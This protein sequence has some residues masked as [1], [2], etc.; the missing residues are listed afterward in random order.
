MRLNFFGAAQTVTGSQHLLEVNGKTLLLDCGLFQGRRKEAFRRNKEFD[1]DVAKLDAVVLSH[2]H[3]D[4][5]GN[6]PNLVKQGYSGPI[7]AQRAT[8]HLADIMLQDSGHIQEYDVQYV[9]RRRKRQGKTPFEPLYTQENAKAAA[10]QFVEKSYAEEFE[11]IPG[12]VVH[13]VDAGHILG[14]AS[15]VLDIEEKGEKVRL[16]FSGDIG[17]PNLPLL[18]D[19][20]MP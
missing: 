16:W 20:V 1:F 14:S 15:V 2:A 5:S 8:A 19:P 18:R 17:R 3:I 12:V 4:H 13:F 10:S 7:Y 6:L 11:P 9:N